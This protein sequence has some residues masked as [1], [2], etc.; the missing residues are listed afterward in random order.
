MSE[1]TRDGLDP[2]DKQIADTPRQGPVGDVQPNENDPDPRTRGGRKQE[3]VEDRPEVSTVKPEDYP[4]DQ[5]AN[6]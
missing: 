2:E 5:R 3:D 1:Q 6:G 4:K